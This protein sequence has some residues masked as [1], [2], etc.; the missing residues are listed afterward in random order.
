MPTKPILELIA[1]IEEKAGKATK[2]PY[3]VE[4]HNYRKDV[5]NKDRTFIAES[6]GDEDSDFIAVANPE[7]IQR[8]TSTLKEAL[9]LIT[10]LERTVNDIS[11]LIDMCGCDLSPVKCPAH[12]LQERARDF[13]RRARG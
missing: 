7:N 9:E 6:C 4:G 12:T 8:L 3:H 5:L 2:G 10:E 13:L 1:E 11:G